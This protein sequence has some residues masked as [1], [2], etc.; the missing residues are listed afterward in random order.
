MPGLL[1]KSWDTHYGRRGAR[2]SLETKENPRKSK[3]RESGCPQNRLAAKAWEGFGKD[4]AHF[5]DNS[6][7]RQ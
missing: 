7:M 6:A 5:I 2:E 4:M 1:D 3:Y